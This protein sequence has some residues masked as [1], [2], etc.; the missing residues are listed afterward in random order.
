MLPLLIPWYRL[1]LVLEIY[2]AM[3]IE[4]SKT[5]GENHTIIDY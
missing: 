1:M 5:V 2:S 4:N 3:T